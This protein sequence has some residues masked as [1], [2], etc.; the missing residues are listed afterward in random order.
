MANRV[1]SDCLKGVALFGVIGPPLGGLIFYVFG[2]AWSVL[3]GNYIGGNFLLVALLFMMYSYIAGF[4]PTVVVG[5]VAG[6]F[7]DRHDSIRSRVAFAA[8]SGVTGVAISYLGTTPA[9]STQWR[10]L[11]VEGLLCM[12]SGALLEAVFRRRTAAASG[13]HVNHA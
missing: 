12:A 2:S 8:F 5:A 6:L 3:A 1:I 4:L 7:R 9:I 10:M 11:L 13:G